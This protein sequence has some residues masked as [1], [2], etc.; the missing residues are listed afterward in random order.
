MISKIAASQSYAGAGDTPGKAPEQPPQPAPKAAAPEAEA[1]PL[2]RLEIK[3]D[4]EGRYVYTL[5]DRNTGRTVV[6]IPR[7]A[8]AQMASSED[9]EAGAVVST[10]A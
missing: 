10:K 8:L 6:E 3:H 7:E 2:L 4:S 1:E 9:Y 5:T